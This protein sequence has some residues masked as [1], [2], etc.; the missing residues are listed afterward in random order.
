MTNSHVSLA[1]GAFYLRQQLMHRVRDG[2]LYCSNRAVEI[3]SWNVEGL[4][5][6]KLVEL[7]NYMLEMQLAEGFF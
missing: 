3:A 1:D 5:D 7:Q 4:T 2:Q 6:I